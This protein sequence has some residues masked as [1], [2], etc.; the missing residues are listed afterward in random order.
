MSDRIDVRWDAFL[1]HEWSEHSFAIE[2][3]KYLKGR[4]ADIW[5]DA[6]NMKGDISQAMAEGVDNSTYFL[7]VVTAAYQNKVNLATGKPENC[8]MEYSFALT[9]KGKDF[10]ILIVRDNTM[11]NPRES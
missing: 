4:G 8:E 1:S 9:K 11:L 5:I 2:L 7:I 3:S 10:F 6:S